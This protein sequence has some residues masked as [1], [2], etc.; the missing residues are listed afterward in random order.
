MTRMVNISYSCQESLT[1]NSLTFL[2]D[3]LLIKIIFDIE[4][5][6]EPRGKRRKVE[7]NETDGKSMNK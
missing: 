6:E 2:S 1:F 5:Q 4:P 7:D 3:T